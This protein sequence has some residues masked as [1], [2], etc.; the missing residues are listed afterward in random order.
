MAKSPWRLANSATP[1]PHRPLHTGKEIDRSSSSSSSAV[2]HTPV[3]NADAGTDLA[4]LAETRSNVASRATATAGYS[5][6]GS[7]WTSEPPMVP[8][9]RIWKWP[10]Y[11]VTAASRGTSAA[12]VG[13]NSTTASRVPALTT[14]DPLSRSMPRSSATR[15][16]STK[17]PKRAKRKLSIGTRLCPPARILASSPSSASVASTSSRSSGAWYSNGAGFMLRPRRRAPATRAAAPA[18]RPARPWPSAARHRRPR[19]RGSAGS[20]PRWP[21]AARCGEV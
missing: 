1:N 7:A 12:T 13:S 4:P 14:S 18:A 10:M 3:K 17:C 5:A 16:M 11:G 19:T 21:A 6:A 20:T 9:L 2:D 8:R 15:P